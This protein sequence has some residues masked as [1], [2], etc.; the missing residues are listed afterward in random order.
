MLLAAFGIDLML[1]DPHRLPHPVRGFGRLVMW[2][3][4]AWRRPASFLGLHAAGM[5]FTLTAV[6]AAAA[7]V[8]L[9]LQLVAGWSWLAAVVTVYWIYTLLAVRSLDDE[10]R[11]VIRHLEK[12]DL[13]AARA[14]LAMIVGRDTAD[15]DEHEVVRGVVETVAEN[16]NDAVVAPLFYFVIAGPVGIAVYKAANT[17]DSMVGYKNDRHREFGWASARLDD[18]MNLI[19]AR[20]SALLM[21]LASAALR[22][23]AVRALGTVL[24]D[25]SR[26]PSPN[27]GYPEAAMAGALGVQLGGVNFYGGCAS[28]KPF[29]GAPL[30]PL[31]VE[32]FRLARRVLY[33]TAALAVGLSM[34]AVSWRSA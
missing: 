21:A 2:L 14:Q 15:L 18:A 20:L 24:R 29:L 1:G 30:V 7:I 26:Q 25:A 28:V 10:S 17:L 32:S 31:T 33:A 11:A 23:N 22:L 12:E 16:L 4:K 19:P 34:W 3:E 8:W 5:F 9:S 6:G 13:A 27:A